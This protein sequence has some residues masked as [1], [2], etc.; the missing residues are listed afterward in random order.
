[1]NQR[2]ALLIATALTA[3]LLVVGGGLTISIPTASASAAKATPAMAQPA[4]LAVAQPAPPATISANQAA[5]IALAAAPGT[6]LASTP[7]M[8]N[9]QGVV[10][11][12]MLLDRGAVY[13]DATSGQVLANSVAVVAQAPATSE[14]ARVGRAEHREHADEDD[15]D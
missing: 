10:A 9:Y 2:T 1:M 8:V 5:T 7:E 12:E 4:A 15:Q 11:Y 3:F 6:A 13:I 14:Q